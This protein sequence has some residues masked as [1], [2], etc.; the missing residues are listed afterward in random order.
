[1]DR[2][3]GNDFQSLLEFLKGCYAIH[4]LDGFVAH[5]VSTLP[6]L[7]PSDATVYNEYNFKRNR[8]VWQ[9]NPANFASPGSEKIWEEYSHEHPILDHFRRT[10]NG[11]A[12]KFSDFVTKRQ[13]HRTILYNEFFRALHLEHQMT[14][15]LQEPT[16]LLVAI[17]LNRAASDFSERERL[18]LNLLRPHLVQAYQNAEAVTRLFLELT[19]VK[20]ALERLDR[21]VVFLSGDG[22][23]Q[24]MTEIARQWMEEYFGMRAGC[25]DCLPDE[26]ERWVRHQKAVLGEKDKAPPPRKPLVVQGEEADLLVCLVS[27]LDQSLLLLEKRQTAVDPACLEF[28]GLT[29]R[30]AEVLVW[31]TQGKTNA[32]IALILDMRPKTVEKHLERIFNKLGV[33][34]RTA[35]ATLALRAAQGTASGSSKESPAGN[36]R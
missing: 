31:I 1:M 19:H 35:A 7:V 18:V 12:V 17:A 28:L 33:E 2:L 24:S 29:R 16:S 5:V 8:I 23:V 9:Q 20:G 10:K 3:K 26:L 15:C 22:K 30:E 11:Q 34:T 4:D 14:F 13:F 25:A 27:E 32:E 36:G 6:K 21:G